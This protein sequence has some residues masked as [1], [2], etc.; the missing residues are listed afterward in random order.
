VSSTAQTADEILQQAKRLTPDERRRLAEELL[1]S[2]EQRDAS[3]ASLNE[4]RPYWRWLAAAGSAH[5]D[6]TDLSTE[7]YKHVTAASHDEA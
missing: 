6:Y 5:S 4:E 2:L 3:E 1:A 7:K